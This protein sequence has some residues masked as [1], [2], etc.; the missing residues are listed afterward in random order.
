MKGTSRKMSVRT[1]TVSWTLSAGTFIA[2][3]PNAMLHSIPDAD[4]MNHQ[5]RER[6]KQSTLT[7]V[8]LSFMH[9]SSA[10]SRTLT[11]EEIASIAS[12]GDTSSE[13]VLAKSP[14]I[15]L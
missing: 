7:I 13:D 6:E 10:R 5:H 9:V 11:L 8:A 12:L 1:W 2:S 14:S 3:S 4:L 15:N